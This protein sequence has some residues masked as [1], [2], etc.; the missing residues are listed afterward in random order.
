MARLIYELIAEERDYTAKLRV[1]H[2]CYPLIYT[3]I[4]EANLV[5]L[6]F[7]EQYCVEPGRWPIR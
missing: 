2:V 7:V 6:D 1:I 4:W 5:P 3:C